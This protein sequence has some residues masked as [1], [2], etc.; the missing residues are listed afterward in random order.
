MYNNNPVC[1]AAPEM[2]SR[3]MPKSMPKIA[4]ET[5]S[6]V[7]LGLEKTSE[8]IRILYG[9]DIKLPDGE[10]PQS[11]EDMMK[12]ILALCSRQ[13]DMLDMILARLTT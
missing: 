6:F 13:M 10:K 3:E 2:G 11:L 4:D 8:I 5:Q 7:R 12:F 9:E 1:D